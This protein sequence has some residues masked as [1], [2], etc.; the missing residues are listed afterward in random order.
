MESVS[1]YESALKIRKDIFGQRNF[2]VSIAN[3]DLA[4]ALYI[5]EYSTG[6]FLNAS[7]HIDQAINIMT[8][9]VPHNSLILSSAKRVKA[10]ILEE[11]AIDISSRTG[12]SGNII[13][14]LLIC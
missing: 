9:L 8:E 6:R 2:H 14:Q 11:I 13:K 7:K 1:V 5:Q 10:L 12:S 4:Y 3:E